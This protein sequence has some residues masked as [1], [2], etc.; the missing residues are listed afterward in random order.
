[1][2]SGPH[3]THDP[4]G[5]SEPTTKMASWSVQLFLHRWPQS[6]LILY[7]GTP[8]P[9]KKLPLPMGDLDLIWYVVP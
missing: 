5:Q 1:V 8:L 2:G 6:V 4:L 3:L 9:P 7:N